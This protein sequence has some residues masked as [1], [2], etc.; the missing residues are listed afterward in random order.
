MRSLCDKINFMNECIFCEFATG[1]KSTDVVYQDDKVFAFNDKF[2]KYP[3]H[4]L[5]IPKKHVEDVTM[6]KPSD[7]ELVGYI[8]RV[9]VRLAEQR[10]LIESGFRFVINKG[11]NAGQT[12]HHLHVHL[13]GG[14]KLRPV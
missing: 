4:I 12:V 6:A 5:I 11:D 7:D 3:T 10:G 1:L 8:L 2:P 9:G 13:L 14:E